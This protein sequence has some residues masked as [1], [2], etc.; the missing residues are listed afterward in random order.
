M[1]KQQRRDVGAFVESMQC[2]IHMHM[3]LHGAMLV[4]WRN[5]FFARDLGAQ[6]NAVTKAERGLG[7]FLWQLRIFHILKRTKQ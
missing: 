4:V 7:W 1:A 6:A 3:F 2:H 5:W